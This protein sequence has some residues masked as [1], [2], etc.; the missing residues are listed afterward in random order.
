MNKDTLDLLKDMA[1]KLGT[2]AD[3][4]WAVMI[5]Q[6]YVSFVTD[7]ILYIAAGIALYAIVKGVRLCLDNKPAGLTGEDRQFGFTVLMVIFS[8]MG[9]IVCLL[10]V[11]NIPGTITKIVN[12]EYWALRQI[13]ETVKGAK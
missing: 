9:V 1:A 10:I 4:L 2:T 8:V 3:H 5:R 6:A 7:L 11:C 13:L 12:P